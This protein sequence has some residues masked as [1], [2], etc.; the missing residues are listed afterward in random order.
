M[1]LFSRLIRRRAA[2]VR[3]GITD[4][5]SAQLGEFLDISINDDFGANA[6]IVVPAPAVPYLEAY[7]ALLHPVPGI[8]LTAV[9]FLAVS[10]STWAISDLIRAIEYLNN[11]SR[12][13]GWKRLIDLLEL[14]T[15]KVVP[16]ACGTANGSVHLPVE[17]GLHHNEIASPK[18]LPVEL[19]TFGI[20]AT[21]S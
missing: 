20:D 4:L 3:D 11:R 10:I 21:L 5:K 13:N 14:D 8:G 1:P 16:L 15:R 7:V 17:S 19:A 9:R 12:N 2:V 18:P 6:A